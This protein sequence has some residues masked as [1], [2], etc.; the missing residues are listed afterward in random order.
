[1]HNKLPKKPPTGGFFLHN[2]LHFDAD[3]VALDKQLVPLDNRLA[4]PDK[5]LA[6]PDKELAVP[7]KE[8]VVPDKELVE[9]QPRR[10]VSS[11]IGVV[12]VCPYE[13]NVDCY[14]FIVVSYEVVVIAVGHEHQM[15]GYLRACRRA[16]M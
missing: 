15:G 10:R 1:M 2:C 7:D 4:V 3:C 5:E 16:R 13:F 14:E 9:I 11:Q 8:L 12:F 6:V